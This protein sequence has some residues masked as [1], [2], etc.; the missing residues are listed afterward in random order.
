MNEIENNPLLEAALDA[1][2]DAIE[3]T[4]TTE[5]PVTWE[6]NSE[7]PETPQS[8]EETTT[9]EESTTNIEEV[10]MEE[11]T[12]VAVEETPV[13]ETSSI[14][15]MIE[16]LN[17]CLAELETVGATSSRRFHNSLWFETINSLHISLIGVG[18]IGS[19][20]AFCLGRLCPRILKLHDPDKVEEVNMAG[21]LFTSTDI[22]RY[23][24]EALAELIRKTTD[25]WVRAFTY[26]VTRDSRYVF[27]ETN[28]MVCGLDNMEARKDCW[29]IFK[30]NQNTQLFI[31]GRLSLENLQIFCILKN[32]TE[33]Y[34]EYEE[35][36]LFPSSEAIEA[37]CGAK[38][39][40]FTAALIGALITN[41]VINYAT[42]QA[43]KLEVRPLPFYTS[44]DASILS[45]K[46]E[47]L[48]Q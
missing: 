11:T 45:L 38:Q 34:K 8:T 5:A 20:T 7:N 29:E 10:P 16:N 43:L 4:P 32:D 48:C 6:F 37:P 14:P 24:S 33:A 31:D 17:A 18:G 28:I 44:Y 2:L 35:K 26:P 12:T 46:T 15:N 42:N 41:L 39:T 22:G 19:H 40:T 9:T 1:V 27:D 25:T 3:D 21:Q 36:W 47:Y 30:E 23:K 13:E